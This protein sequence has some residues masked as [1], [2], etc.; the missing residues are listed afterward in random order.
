MGRRRNPRPER[1]V[2]VRYQTPDGRRCRSTD[3][4]AQKVTTRSASYFARLVNP[5][6]GKREWVPLE[7]GDLGAA[8]V[9]LREVL[10][11][12]DREALGLVDPT[13]AHAAAPVLEHLW[14][15][16][17]YLRDA[18]RTSPPQ[19][20]MVELRVTRLVTLAGWK[21]LPDIDRPS[22][23]A[24]LAALT[25]EGRSARTRNHYLRHLK[26]FLAWCVAEGRLLRSPAL[27]VPA[28]DWESDVRHPRRSPSDADVEL[29][30]SHLESPDA[31]TRRGMTG[32]QR[33]LGYR[34][35]MA[36]GFRARELRSLS[37]ESFDLD[38]GVVTVQSA[39]AKNRRTAR[40]QLPPWLVEEL[41]A[42]FASG[43]GLWD[44]FPA[45]WPGRVLKADQ[46]AAGVAHR[47]AEGF[48]DFHALRHW[49]CTWVANQPGI[50]PKTLQVLAR[51]ADPGLTLRVY[52]KPQADDAERIVKSMP[53]PKRG[54]SG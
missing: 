10:A 11:E 34:L 37:R 53:S 6:T 36:T 7:T 44:G 19:V 46:E 51:H 32:P 4:G 31:P 49:Y 14:A 25:R 9:R 13:Y 38:A 5:E 29:L 15:W 3:P 16:V 54:R 45:K 30:L 8:W 18:G 35:A 47:T 39:Y 20:R 50:S 26:Q 52:A 17:A 42:W 2:V 12:R 21:R 27:G 24:A 48:F 22:I 23:V 41:R 43:G 33:G 1:P 40:Q 28:V